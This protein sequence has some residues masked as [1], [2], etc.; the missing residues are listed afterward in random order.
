MQFLPLKYWIIVIG[1]SAIIGYYFTFLLFTQK[2]G[3]RKANLLL[4]SFVFVVSYFLTVRVIIFSGFYREFPYLLGT[5]IPCWYLTG[6]LFY[7]YIKLHLWPEYKL[8]LNDFLHGIPF[9]I[10]FLMMSKIIFESGSRKIFLLENPAV[11]TIKIFPF[12]FLPFIILVGYFILSVKLIKNSL[13]SYKL[14]FSNTK[15]DHLEWVKRILIVYIIYLLFDIIT[16]LRSRFFNVLLVEMNFL[17]LFAMSLFI[18]FIVVYSFRNPARI[19]YVKDNDTP[20]YQT[21]NLTDDSMEKYLS[22]LDKIMK[23]EKLYMDNNL[24]LPG[25]AN[26]LNLKPYQVSQIINQKKNS[27]FYDYINSFRVEEAKRRLSDPAQNHISVLG[28]GLDV[29]FNSK[30]SFNSNFKKLENTTPS[31]YRK[32]NNN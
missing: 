3:N 10:V 1:S 13:A 14:F 21:S 9:L 27:N 24:S 19:F 25:L 18:H 8:K 26:K 23:E 22:E 16:S 15:I 20:K 28:I 12:N 6:P 11:N 17:T 32:T 4:A 2:K 7:F 5:A 29:G 30:T 31:A